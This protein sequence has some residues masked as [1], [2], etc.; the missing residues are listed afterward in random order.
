MPLSGREYNSNMVD[1]LDTV[2]MFMLWKARTL[3]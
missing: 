2:G 3:C 1:V